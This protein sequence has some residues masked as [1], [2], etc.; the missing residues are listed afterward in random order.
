[1]TLPHYLVLQWDYEYFVKKQVLPLNLY[2]GYKL[3]HEEVITIILY[4]S[5]VNLHK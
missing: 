1:M 4:K 3:W 2:C 5:A